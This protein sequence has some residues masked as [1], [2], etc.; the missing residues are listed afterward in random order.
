MQTGVNTVLFRDNDKKSLYMFNTEAGFFKNIFDPQLVEFVDAE[1]TN[2][3]SQLY[4]NTS[5]QKKKKKKKV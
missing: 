4:I 3:E 5:M 1:S 2:I